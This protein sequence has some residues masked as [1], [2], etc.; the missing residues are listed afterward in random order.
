MTPVI[1][2]QSLTKSY[3]RRAAVDDLS[4]EVRAGEIY[5][6]LG[7]NGAGKTTTIRMLMGFVKPTRGRT[8]L[9]DPASGGALPRSRIGF[10]PGEVGLPERMTGRA[11]LDL[12]AGLG[13]AGAPLRDWALEVVGLAA[14]DLRRRIRSY[15]RGM[16]Q[17][18]ALVQALQHDPALLVLDE[19][20]SGL[21][22]LVQHRCLAALRGLRDAGKTILFSSHVLSE[23]EAVCDRVGVLR[24]GRLILEAPVAELLAGAPRRLCLLLPPGPPGVAFAPPTIAGAELLH[25]EGAWLVYRVAPGRATMLLDE[26]EALAPTDFRLESNFEE[27][28]LRLYGGRTHAAATNGTKDPHPAVDVPSTEDES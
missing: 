24:E 8:A 17:K 14:D 23:V 13:R 19:P 25:A 18:L 2:A 21:D 7:P 16:K 28:F 4:F 11:F 5:G 15:S 6:C 26:L 3:C 27:S 22:P 1:Q 20:T 9:I 10:V 12:C